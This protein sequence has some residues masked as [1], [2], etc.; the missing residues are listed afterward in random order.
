MNLPPK[1]ALPL[2]QWSIA[3][4]YIVEIKYVE[5]EVRYRALDQRFV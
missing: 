2:V 3:V 1:L 4:V 5:E